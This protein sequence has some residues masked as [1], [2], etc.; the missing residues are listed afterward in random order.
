MAG[1][2]P[3]A[4]ELSGVVAVPSVASFSVWKTVDM[5]LT[6]TPRMTVARV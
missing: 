6:G 5:V 1:S 4:L 3:G 2:H